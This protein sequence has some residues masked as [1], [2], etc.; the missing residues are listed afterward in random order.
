MLDGLRR[1]I[2]GAIAPR[3]I[4]LPNTP[5]IPLPAAAPASESRPQ[6]AGIPLSS[7]TSW[8]DLLGLVSGYNS[9]SA[10]RAMRHGA[11]YACMR[12]IA[13]TIGQLPIKTYQYD[14]DTGVSIEA[15]RHPAARLLRLRPN[16]RMTAVMFW[17]AVVASA[18][19]RGNGYAW[20]ER[21]INGTPIALWPLPG[22]RVGPELVQAGP[23]KGRIIYRLTLDDGD[24]VVADMDDI[25][26]IPGSLEWNGWEARSPLSAAASAINT[27]LEADEYAQR[28]FQN[29]ATPPTV[30]EYPSKVGPELAELIRTEFG[31]KG[32]R[33]N[34]HKVRVLSEGGKI[35]QLALSAED[36]QLLE[37][38]RFAVDDIARVFG[39]PPHMVGS[40]TTSTS[41]GSGIE[42]QGIG[43][44]TYTLGMHFAAIE[45][46]LEV[47]IFRDDTHFAEFDQSALVRGDFKTRNEGYKSAMG[48]SAGPGWMTAN[49]VRK[50]ENM[51]PHPD[52]DVLPTWPPTPPGAAPADETEPETESETDESSPT[53]TPGEES[54]TNRPPPHRSG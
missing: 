2:A 23:L 24:Y 28:F 36:A 3:A 47:K 8:D 51:P 53:P 12:V 9:M 49:D 7:L 34:R 17:R 18:V 42:Q 45:Q 15:P 22:G 31:A 10:D 35:S 27:G 39:V 37:T 6:A 21:S 26:H 46:E 40:V 54:G 29:D 43:F 52:G 48:G 5:A 1:S 25:L 38:R 14:D 13:G 32:T 30:L 16:P 11:V 33:E 20:I 19:L 4:V 44:V 41:W 50:K